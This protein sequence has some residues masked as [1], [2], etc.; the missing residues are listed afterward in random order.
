MTHHDITMTVDCRTCPVREVRCGECI[1]PVF[2]ELEAREV[3]GQGRLDADEQRAVTLL[4][5][6]GLVDPETAYR[7]R[8][9]LEPAQPARGR[10]TGRAVG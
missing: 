1:V 6:A 8:A 5:R 7:A 2:F 10:T 9:V 4:L 3:R